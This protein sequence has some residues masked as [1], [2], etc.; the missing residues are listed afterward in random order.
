MQDN[1]AMETVKGFMPVFFRELQRDGQIDRAVAVARGVVR[2]RRDWWVPVLF[3]RLESGRLFAPPSVDQPGVAAP[4]T[5]GSPVSTDHSQPPESEGYDLQVV[6]DLLLAG[7]SARTL[8]RMIR[9][10]SNPQLRQVVNQLG[11]SDGLVDIVDKTLEYC[12]DTVL[13]GALLAE[14]KRENP[15][16]YQRFEPRLRAST[17]GSS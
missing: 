1:V 4:S 6:R 5:A 8:P 17:S 12:E 3:T 11:P 2:N 13:V 9:Y 15:R 14:V 16:Q 7:F 10:S